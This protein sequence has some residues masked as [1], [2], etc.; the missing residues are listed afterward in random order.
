MTTNESLDK[1]SINTQVIIS[2]WNKINNSLTLILREQMKTR[3][4][5]I[6]QSSELSK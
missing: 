5:G 1:L 6:L 4:K 2:K 3:S